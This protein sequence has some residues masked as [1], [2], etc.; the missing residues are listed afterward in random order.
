MGIIEFFLKRNK[1]FAWVINIVIF[2]LGIV[3]VRQLSVRL[4]PQIKENFVTIESRIGDASPRQLESQ[5]SIF[6][7][8]EFG[9][10][11]GLKEMYSEIR[12]GIATT[13]LK[14]DETVS[15]DESF[16]NVLAAL[17]RIR[18]DLPDDR[19]LTM[20][21]NKSDSNADPVL[22]LLFT[23][24]NKSQDINTLYDFVSRNFENIVK[25]QPGVAKVQTWGGSKYEAKIILNSNKMKALGIHASDVFEAL[26]VQ[27]IK[28]DVG[29]LV[30]KDLYITVM[31]DNSVKSEEDLESISIR[32]K[33]G[34]DNNAYVKIKD[35][36]KVVF[37]PA[38]Q[39]MI[40]KLNGERVVVMSIV[41]QAN[42]S[43]VDISNNIKSKLNGWS[44]LFPSDVEMGIMFNSSTYIEESI[45]Q[46]YKAIF[47]AVGLV[48]AIIFIFLGSWKASIIPLIT[49]PISLVGAFLVLWIFNCS[50][51]ILTMLGLV[52][53]VGLVVDDAICVLEN[54]YRYIEL[55]DRPH[56]AACNGGKEIQFSIIAMTLTLA[57]VYAPIALI[58]GSIGSM[59]KEFAIALSA[60]VLFSG[61]VALTIS[62]IMCAAIL[63]HNQHDTKVYL[64]MQNIM[65][66]V[67]RVYKKLLIKCIKY[68]FFTIVFALSLMFASVLMY[69]RTKF[70]QFP[71][72][73]SR[74]IS[75]TL[76]VSPG[77]D[78]FYT[79]R[80]TDALYNK[81]K[82]MFPE[83]KYTMVD[84]KVRGMTKIYHELHTKGDSTSESSF[85][86]ASRMQKVFDTYL[87]GI[88]HINI[89]ANN[90]SSVTSSAPLDE[91]KIQVFGKSDKPL[92]D[93]ENEVYR[94]TDIIASKFKH[95]YIDIFY[96]REPKS[97]QKVLTVN[98]YVAAEYNINIAQLL[99]DLNMYFQENI[100]VTKMNKKDK[101]YSIRI[102]TDD[103]SQRHL[104]MMS[105]RGIKD[106]KS[107]SIPLKSVIDITEVPVESNIE[108]IDGRRC[109][110]FVF[111][112][113]HG[114]N[115]IDAYEIIKPVL[116]A[117][118]NDDYAFSPLG[119]VK[120]VLEE[121]Q[122]IL[123]IF[124]L[125]IVFI[126]LVMSAQF[127]SFLDPIIV[128]FTVPMA[129]F[130]AVLTIWAS[131]YFG[132]NLTINSYTQVGF[133]TLIGLITKTGILIV[134]F[135]NANFSLGDDTYEESVIKSCE[136]RFRPIIMTTLAMSISSIPLILSKSTGYEARQQIG[137]C[138]IGGM[139][140]GTLLTLFVVPAMY[141]LVNDIR[142]FAKNFRKKHADF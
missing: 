49:I 97:W 91:L 132:G 142:F 70:E 87:T 40:S 10:I 15:S 23:C 48:L 82:E 17:A 44:E 84:A 62:P 57:I 38:E 136:L 13:T 74:K 109:M 67:I 100:S 89:S 64:M 133:I 111:K 108:H 102:V 60:S 92:T 54:I 134:D 128:L 16:N 21:I 63:R 11:Y 61:V 75:A 122:N 65:D 118:I 26:K 12:T 120:S 103:R 39:E 30:S 1:S 94:L 43:P 37:E 53:A 32:L 72:E 130:G 107:C 110:T 3:G 31:F 55:G 81:I 24:K 80:Q 86:I 20:E 69:N 8:K 138:I 85:D 99:E 124:V 71:P 45:Y 121:Q 50:I 88:K 116:K 77:Y 127:N 34:D 141:A 76:Q 4:Y 123:Y 36:A 7:E 135:A 126:Y 22:Y 56:D 58:K 125:A 19:K 28:G 96:T 9:G 35:I 139:I 114:I 68:R 41:P 131:G 59:F 93:L 78:I 113:N 47:E 6:M 79:L 98:K 14:F 46:V 106:G 18:K 66:S 29:R 27:N 25:S 42:S 104:E 90:V 137:Y 5:V 83:V 140:F 119:I 117:E 129:L 2:V 95:L 33:N 52:L 51:N 112:L 101:I 115:P 105:V 73:D